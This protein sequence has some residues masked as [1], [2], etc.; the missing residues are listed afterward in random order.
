MHLLNLF[1]APRARGTLLES[2]EGI[3]PKQ[4]PAAGPAALAEPWVEAK[5]TARDTNNTRQARE[6]A[7]PTQDPHTGTGHISPAQNGQFTTARRPR[8]SSISHID[9]SALAMTIPVPSS[10]L[11]LKILG[12]NS[13]TSMV[14]PLHAIGAW[15]VDSSVLVANH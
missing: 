7:R 14:S 10:R 1:H 13:G 4:G 2:G 11:D 5:A 8:P 9:I 6:R 3:T 12:M 15:D